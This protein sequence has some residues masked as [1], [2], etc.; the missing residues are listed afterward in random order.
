MDDIALSAALKAYEN[1]AG[2]TQIGKIEAACRVYCY[3]R[4]RRHDSAMPLES[5]ASQA[6]EIARLQE[7]KERLDGLL[8]DGCLT[9][10]CPHEKQSDCDR[11]IA[12]QV[13]VIYAERDL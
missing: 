5:Q 8:A 11:C 1:G 9:G 10:D 6:A 7:D 4:S 13:K 3:E 12:R 2:L